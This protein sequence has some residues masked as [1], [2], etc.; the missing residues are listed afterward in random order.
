MILSCARRNRSV[1]APQALLL[2]NNAAVR[3]QAARFAARLRQQAGDSLQHQVQLG[4]ELALARP[5]KPFELRESISF[6]QSAGATGLADF[7]HALFNL[8]EFVYIP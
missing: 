3:M 5:P 1:T 4:F 2:M 7:C 6:I 8:N